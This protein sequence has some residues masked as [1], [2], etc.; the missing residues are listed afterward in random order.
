MHVHPLGAGQTALGC[1]F[2]QGSNQQQVLGTI[3]KCAATHAKGEWIVGGQWDA[4]SYGRE[5][6]ERRQLDRVSPDNPVALTDISLHS[7]WVNSKALEL[8]G[9][10]AKTPNPPGGI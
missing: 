1:N 8:A 2:P 4:A 10:T 7:L 6:P 5:P 3:Q 9:V